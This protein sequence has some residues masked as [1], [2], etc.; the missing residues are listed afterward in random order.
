M[1]KKIKTKETSLTWSKL[2]LLSSLHKPRADAN[3]MTIIWDKKLH[4]F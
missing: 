4:N 2:K 1:G 3:I